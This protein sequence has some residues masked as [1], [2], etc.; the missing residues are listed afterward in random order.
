MDIVIICALNKFDWEFHSGKCQYTHTYVV[1]VP[2]Q[3][4][5]YEIEIVPSI[6]VFFSMFN[7]Y[8][9]NDTIIAM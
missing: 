5:F 3:I 4:T 6:D 1:A 9:I 7:F 2:S 8:I